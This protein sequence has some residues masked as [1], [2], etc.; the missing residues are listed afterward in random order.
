MAE[1]KAELAS[2]LD[3]SLNSKE[4]GDDFLKR[5]VSACVRVFLVLCPLLSLN[6]SCCLISYVL[7]E[8]WKEKDTSK[9]PTYKE[10]KG[11]DEPEQ[12]DDSEDE[13]YLDKVDEFESKYNFRYEEPGGA[14]VIMIV[15][16]A[17]L[18]IRVQF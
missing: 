12:P 16:V 1:K 5:S 17:L 10:I 15:S 11:E 8:W 4:A 13:E 6:L 2:L 9:L 7:N 18:F 3:Q 14:Q